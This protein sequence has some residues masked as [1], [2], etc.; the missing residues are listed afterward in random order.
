MRAVGIVL[1]TLGLLGTAGL[2]LLLAVADAAGP[3][4]LQ[5]DAPIVLGIALVCVTLLGAGAA[6]VRRPRPPD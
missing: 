1:L 4:S 6:L 5:G 2:I 3:I